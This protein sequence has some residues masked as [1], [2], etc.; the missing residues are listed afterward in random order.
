MIHSGKASNPPTAKDKE[1]ASSRIPRFTKA[2]KAVYQKMRK[3]QSGTQ[4]TL[5]AYLTRV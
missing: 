3:A 1:L 5:D 2:K 4:N